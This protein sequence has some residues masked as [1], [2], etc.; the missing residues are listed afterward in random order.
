MAW[1]Y[2]TL[3]GAGSDPTGA[4][5]TAAIA[6]LWAATNSGEG[7]VVFGT[8]TQKAPLRAVGNQAV[9]I[10]ANRSFLGVKG[11]EASLDLMS[12]D[13]AGTL[14]G[15]IGNSGGLAAGIQI[16]N[17]RLY[18]GRGLNRFS[19]GAA[20]CPNIILAGQ[21]DW[22]STVRH[23]VIIDN[24]INYE[25]RG[26]AISLNALN[27]WRVSRV[28]NP[29]PSSAPEGTCHH[30][31]TDTTTYD[32][33]I[34]NGIIEDSDLDSYGNECLKMENHNNTI[35]RRTTIRSY[36]SLVQDNADA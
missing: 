35:V 2:Y 22:S 1:Q 4:L 11:M 12:W 10:P 28:I 25:P 7:V 14:C 18:G 13:S 36:V 24:V 17:L 5:N 32:K 15:L 29:R 27:G 34:Q 23:N 6:A 30:F 33:P 8:P 19:L 21:N 20:D 31:D 16:A 9:L 3:L 26:Q